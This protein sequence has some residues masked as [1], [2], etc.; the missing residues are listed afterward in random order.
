MR[1]DLASLARRAWRSVDLCPSICATQHRSACQSE[2]AGQWQRAA[3][4][5][6]RSF[7]AESAA[8]E[9]AAP[10]QRSRT[11]YALS[12][13]PGA[14]LA[15]VV[16][17][18][19]VEPPCGRHL[20][21]MTPAAAAVAAPRRAAAS[22][23]RSRRRAFRASSLSCR[24]GRRSGRPRHRPGRPRRAPPPPRSQRAPAGAHGDPRD[25]RGP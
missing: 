18:R 23:T 6:R 25:R 5:S 17:G 8:A 15:P 24:K 3:E 13:A 20:L 19:A 7:S 14:Q 9:P 1:C 4:A 12:T 11:V 10:S 2:A 16:T 22:F 21:T